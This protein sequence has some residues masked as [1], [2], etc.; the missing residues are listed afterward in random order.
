MAKKKVEKVAGWG[1]I[2]EM[3]GKK[4]EKESKNMDCGPWHQQIMQKHEEGG[5]FF[6]RALFI[7][8][9]L[10]ILNTLGVISGVNIWIQVLLGVG[11]AL[12]TF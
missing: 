1:K 4:I 6:G 10:I 9:L 2:G 12:M 5:G 8:A 11:F 7:I 3:I